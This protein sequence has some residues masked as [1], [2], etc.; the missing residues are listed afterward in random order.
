MGYIFDMT[1]VTKVF[2][3]DLESLSMDALMKSA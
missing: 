1:R 2:E 3:Y